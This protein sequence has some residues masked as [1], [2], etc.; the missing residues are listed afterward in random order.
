MI[1][2]AYIIGLLGS[3]FIVC[4]LFIETYSLIVSIGHILN[5][6]R[7]SAFPILPIILYV[8]GWSVVNFSVQQGVPLTES[9]MNISYRVLVYLSVFHLSYF[10]VIWW[11]LIPLLKK[12]GII[13][14]GSTPDICAGRGKNGG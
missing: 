1:I 12:M 3:L 9:F 8:L 6:T 2:V 14:N 13:K 10:I 11:I 5:K 4:G 7:Q